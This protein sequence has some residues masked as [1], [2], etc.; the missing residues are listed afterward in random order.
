MKKYYFLLLALAGCRQNTTEHQAASA[1]EASKA[2]IVKPTIPVKSA[3][4][5]ASG[6]REESGLNDTLHVGNG[7][8]L[9]LKP[10]S[11]SDFANA[12]RMRTYNSETYAEQ[13][14]LNQEPPNRVR[15]N[16]HRL[17]LTLLNGKHLL[18]SDNTYEMRGDQNEEIDTYYEFKGSV[19]HLPYWMVDS[20][21]YEGITTLLI[22]KNTGV[23]SRLWGYPVFSPD[24]RHFVVPSPALD[25][26]IELNGLQL[27]DNSTSVP[28][29]RW[30]RT[31][32]HW[33]PS[34]IHWLDNQTLAIE[35]RR[36][37]LKG[38]ISYVRLILP[39]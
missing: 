14:Y 31:L 22:H 29:L 1:S 9:Q 19:P 10:G 36:L 18:L 17:Y 28:T 38:R 3:D 2:P 26:D 39:N 35:Q 25:S 30:E 6:D 34:R 23:I 24:K 21:V 11:K 16:K 15:R 27:F 20:T 7:I 8:V 4:T 33:E 37:E 13:K 5:Y 32:I 12:P